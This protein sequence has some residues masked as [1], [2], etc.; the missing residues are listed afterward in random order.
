MLTSVFMLALASA[1]PKPDLGPQ[2]LHGR[3]TAETLVVEQR[4]SERAPAKRPITCKLAVFTTPAGDDARG[5]WQFSVKDRSGARVVGFAGRRQPNGDLALERAYLGSPDQ[6]DPVR[7]GLC[8]VYR[9][10][11]EASVVFCAAT[12]ANA[13]YAGMYAITFQVDDLPRR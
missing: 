4:S 2:I 5:M 11:G 1:A 9:H 10:P 8:K 12:V 6:P 3:C 7:K 13:G